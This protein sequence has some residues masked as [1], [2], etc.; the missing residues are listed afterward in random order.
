MKAEF[1]K[2]VDFTRL[3]NVSVFMNASAMLYQK[4]TGEPVTFN[5]GNIFIADSS[6]FSILSYPLVKGQPRQ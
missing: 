5:E 4:G 2:V 6:F 1:S 3:V